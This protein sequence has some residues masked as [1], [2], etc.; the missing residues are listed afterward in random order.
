MNYEG[1]LVA[2]DI[3][4]GA[5]TFEFAAALTHSLSMSILTAVANWQHTFRPHFIFCF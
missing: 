5:H 3:T 1:L 4:A 2:S